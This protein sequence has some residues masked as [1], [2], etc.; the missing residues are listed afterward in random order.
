MIQNIDEWIEENIE[1]KLSP[2]TESEFDNGFD[3]EW[4]RRGR[5]EEEEWL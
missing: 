4:R 1:K 2:I 5:E 3:D